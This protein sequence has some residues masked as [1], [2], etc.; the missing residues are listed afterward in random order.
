MP[1]GLIRTEELLLA[2]RYYGVDRAVLHDGHRLRLLEAAR[3]GAREVGPRE[4]AARRRPR[5]PHR[6][7]AGADRA[8]PGQRARRPRQPPDRRPDH[9]GGVQGRRRSERCFPSRSPEGLRPWQPL[10]LYMGGVRENEDWTLRVDTGG[11]SPVARRL[12]PDVR[13][14]RPQLPALAER[15]PHSIRSRARRC[16]TTS[17]SQSQ[18]STAPAKETSFFDGIDTTHPRSVHDAE[19]DRRPPAPRR[20]SVRSIARSR[21]RCRRSRWTI[22]RPRCR[23]SRAGLR[24]RARAIAA[25]RRR[26]DA[27]A[28]LSVKEQQFADAINTALGIDFTAIAQPAGSPEPTGP[29]QPSR[30]RR[31]W[32]RSSQGRRSTCE[33]RSPTAVP[34]TSTQVRRRR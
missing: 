21:R 18:S 5:H 25:A 22:R 1:L 27:R 15:R 12:V 7:P 34:W 28:L 6:A 29:L 16:R 14:P 13:A 24:R 10:K 26:S 32:R 9:A 17:G 2:D 23:R 31:R 3:G 11:Y 8:L 19:A 20:C 33:R 30:R 4:R